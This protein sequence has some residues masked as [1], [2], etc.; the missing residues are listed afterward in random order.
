MELNPPTEI[1]IVSGIRFVCVPCSVH[2]CRMLR[3]GR[4]LGYIQVV[5]AL[6]HDP[7]AVTQ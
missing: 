2:S 3:D 1:T 6:I 7:A 5:L 4:L